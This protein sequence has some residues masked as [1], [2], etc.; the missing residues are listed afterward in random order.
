MKEDCKTVAL[1]E[2]RNILAT[3][4]Q[5]RKINPVIIPIINAHLE[6]KSISQIGAQFGLNALEVTLILEKAEV[7]NYIN[8]FLLGYGFLN[9]LKRVDLI[10]QVINKKIAEAEEYDA[11]Y[12]TKD[13]LDWVKLL[14]KE[15]EI[16]GA[17]K[18]QPSV[19]VNNQINN[20]IA[21]MVSELLDA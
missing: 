10:D 5:E 8:Q 3:E 7:R 21:D 4:L 11:P 18:S 17:N 2:V 6:N 13:L 20:N 16:I 14:Q 12:S 19:V 1:E 15:V 9:R